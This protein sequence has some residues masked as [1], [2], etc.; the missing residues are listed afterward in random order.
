MSE[1]DSGSTAI[2][3]EAVAIGDTK[4]H[5]AVLDSTLAIVRKALSSFSQDV[6]DSARGASPVGV[7]QPST[8][9]TCVQARS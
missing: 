8:P 5:E 6:A 4:L 9:T 3:I 1:I 7:P 2:T